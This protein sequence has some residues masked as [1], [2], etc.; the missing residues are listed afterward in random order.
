[1]GD[2][3]INTLTMEQYLAL[4]RGNQASGVVKP[5]IRGN[6][7]FEI[8]SQFMR[9]LREDTFFRNKND[10][11]YEHVERILDIVSLFNIPG[12]TH[13]VV[14]LRVFP[15]TLTGAAKRWADRLSPGTINTWDLLKNA[16]IQRRVSN[17]SSAGITTIT[18]KLDSLGRDMKKLKENVHAIQV[19]CENYGGDHLNNECPLHEEVK[20]VKEVKYR[21]F[22]R[23]FPNN[24]RNGARYC[25][26]PPGYYNRLD[27]LP[28]FSEKKPSVEE[29]M[30]KH[31]E[32]STRKRAEMEEWAKKLL[33]STE[34]NTRNQN[35]S[36]KNL[37]TQIDQL[38]KDYKAKAANEV[39]DPSVGQCKAIFANNEVPRDEAS[40]KETTK[41]QG[42]SFISDDNVEVPEE[43]EERIHGVLICQL[44]PNELNP[45]SFTLPC[46]IGSLNFYAMADLGASVNIMP[47]LMLTDS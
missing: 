15:I 44:P 20:S 29:L 4:T 41:L 11:A 39:P 9:E 12:V 25:I 31:I 1:M 30:N 16:F 8:N 3:D 19:R 18:N 23:P 47:R 34:L 2:A 37:E 5:D 14:M 32:E 26:G 7:N 27:N 28:P 6:V 43:I 45:G 17:D 33:E 38:A 36:L 22:G 21:E 24:N 46:T 42:V 13:D 35:A 10:D 40:S